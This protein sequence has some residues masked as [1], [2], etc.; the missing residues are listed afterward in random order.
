MYVSVGWMFRL[1]GSLQSFSSLASSPVTPNLRNL[2]NSR[3]SQYQ[4]K[5]P[6]Y[7][8]GQSC[9]PTAEESNVPFWRCEEIGWRKRHSDKR[10]RSCIPS[11]RER[12]SKCL[13]P[14]SKILSRRRKDSKGKISCWKCL[15]LR[16]LR[17]RLMNL[18]GRRLPAA[19]RESRSGTLRENLSKAGVVFETT[20]ILDGGAMAN[21]GARLSVSAYAPGAHAGSMETIESLL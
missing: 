10:D 12:A 9:L 15:S 19:G 14:I 8:R 21:V 16:T 5:Y 13:E 4:I 2:S 1:L 18:A 6:R 11:S 3:F 20:S 7:L 17:F